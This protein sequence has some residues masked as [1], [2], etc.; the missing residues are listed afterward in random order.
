MNG[1]STPRTDEQNPNAITTEER[2]TRIREALKKLHLD[3][4]TSLAE[5]TQS[6]NPSFLDDDIAWLHQVV[7]DV[8]D[9][10]QWLARTWY[11]TIS[12]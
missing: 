4:L 8:K 1:V 11:K 10:I 5:R 2:T 12:T 3:D 6:R 9:Y 7:T